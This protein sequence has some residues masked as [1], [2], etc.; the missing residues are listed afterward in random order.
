ML[1]EEKDDEDNGGSGDNDS[2]TDDS[3]IPDA[4]QSDPSLDDRVVKEDREPKDTKT[5]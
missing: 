3:G 2:S 5:S 1:S 4:D